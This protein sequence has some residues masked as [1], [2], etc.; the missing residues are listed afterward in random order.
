MKEYLK[1]FVRSIA[2][3]PV[4]GG[5]IRT[6]VGIVRLPQTRDMLFAVNHQVVGIT[7]QIDEMNK[8]INNIAHHVN[9]ISSQ[10]NEIYHQIDEIK[11]HQD[12][13]DTEYLPGLLDSLEYQENLKKSLPVVLRKQIRKSRDLEKLISYEE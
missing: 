8:R 5:P 2:A 7:G 3:K 6:L 10:I 1:R 13:Y 9:E 11:K 4:I 12:K